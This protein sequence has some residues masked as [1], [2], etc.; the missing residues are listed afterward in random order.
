MTVHDGHIHVRP[1]SVVDALIAS[2]G[3]HTSRSRSCSSLMPA[4]IG[5][6]QPTNRVMVLSSMEGFCREMQS[7]MIYSENSPA[8]SSL[9]ARFLSSCKRSECPSVVPSSQKSHVPSRSF[10]D[11]VPTPQHMDSSG[12]SPTTPRP[13]TPSDLFGDPCAA[14]F[15]T[16]T[17]DDPSTAPFPTLNSSFSKIHFAV[18]SNDSFASTISSGPSTSVDSS[19]LFRLQDELATTWGA[20][21]APSSASLT[22]MLHLGELESVTMF[23]GGTFTPQYG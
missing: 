16:S 21:R 2:R 8:T 9:H 3:L 23:S 19:S 10:A 17:S 13:T 11:S 12:D 15:P 5:G 1:R 6:H 18:L 4:G 14:S 22:T 20:L 7:T